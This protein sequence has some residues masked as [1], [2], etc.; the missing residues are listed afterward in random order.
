MDNATFANLPDEAKGLAQ[1]AVRTLTKLLERL[2]DERLRC[3]FMGN[4]TTDQNYVFHFDDTSP[5]NFHLAAAFAR[6]K[7]KELNAD[8]VMTVL[9][10]L[11]PLSRTAS[12]SIETRNGTY[13][14]GFPVVRKQGGG[15]A[16]ALG[17]GQFVRLRKHTSPFARMLSARA[18][19]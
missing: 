13:A 17:P 4:W 3:C 19:R 11:G 9:D 5:E 14:C 2:P 18:R 10:M 8:Y 1:G 15:E 16:M 12:V 7:V 6:Q